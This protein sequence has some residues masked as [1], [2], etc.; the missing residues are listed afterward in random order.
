VIPDGDINS[1]TRG[2]PSDMKKTTLT[3][4]NNIGDTHLT[5]ES[6]EAAC[7]ICWG[8][9]REDDAAAA[10]EGKRAEDINPL[11]SVC[12][13][14]GTLKNIHLECLR[15]WMNQKRTYKTHRKQVIIKFKKLDCELCK[16]LYPF[17][18]AY[19]NKIIDIV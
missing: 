16:S 17:K 12:K 4:K 2:I 7:R 18:I 6:D 11:I 5:E 19:N 1:P 13:C 3:A 9:K 14:I 10:T 15:G 8:T